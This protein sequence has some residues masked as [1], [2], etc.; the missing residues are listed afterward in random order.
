MD[1]NAHS[2]PFPRAGN[3]IA[4]P[5][6][7]GTPPIE[8][9][10]G[11]PLRR[12][13][14]EPRQAL[15]RAGQSMHALYLVHAGHFKV[16]VMS[17]DGREKITGFRMRG[18][19]LGLD[20]LGTEAYGCDVVALDLSEAWE[21]PCGLINTRAA[22]R[23]DLHRQ[24]IAASAQEIRRDWQWMLS[25]ATLSAEQRVAAFLIDLADRQ[26]AQGCSPRRLLLRMSRA[27]LGNFL[28]IQLETVTRA[29][30]RMARMGII[31]VQR[32]GV[33]LLDQDALYAL[34]GKA[35]TCH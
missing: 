34:A 23:P 2:N 8:A 13:R 17:P 30:S 4:L 6:G 20:A 14:I 27:D 16:S 24:L 12:R 15:F 1:L 29:L 25:L 18:D 31:S 26:N 22:T 7:V 5:A 3:S 9:W 10:G 28:A 35:H 21:L 19:F 32:R 11:L 33:E